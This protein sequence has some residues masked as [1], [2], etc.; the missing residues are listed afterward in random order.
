MSRYVTV[1]NGM[2]LCYNGLSKNC[3]SIVMRRGRAGSSQ[4]KTLVG[5][6]A[7]GSVRVARSQAN[8]TP[9]AK[10]SF[11]SRFCMRDGKIVL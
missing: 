3:K 6:H 11:E 9:K 10:Y 7:L 8:Q 4:A 5:W 2:R 1:C